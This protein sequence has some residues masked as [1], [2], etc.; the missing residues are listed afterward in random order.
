MH[1]HSW[2]ERRWRHLDSC[3]FKTFVRANVPR[4]QCPEH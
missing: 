2:S 1:V 4:V 3:Q